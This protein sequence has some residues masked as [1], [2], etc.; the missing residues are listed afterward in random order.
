MRRS[1]PPVP[2][3][4]AEAARAAYS[5]ALRW[6]AARELSSSRVRERLLARGFTA[7]ATD[8]A[9]GRLRASRAIDDPRAAA[10]CARTLVLVKRR[11]RLRAI[12]ELEWM[13]FDPLLAREAV[14]SALG[15]EG[16]R[17]LAEAALASRLRGKRPP[18][19]PAVRRRLFAALVRQGFPPPLVLD[20]LRAHRA[21][22][23]EPV[24]E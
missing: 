24:D 20:L 13:G 4:P 17:S 18:L 8:S 14:T 7:I 1:G 11:G 19:D 6:L 22:P 9:I 10:A 16:E 2:E 21:E 23:G 5:C 12:R 15:A 3:D